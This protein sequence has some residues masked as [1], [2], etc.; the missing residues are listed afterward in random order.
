MNKVKRNKPEPKSKGGFA[1]G[2]NQVLSGRFLLRDYVQSNL[3]FLIYIVFLMLSYIAYGYFAENNMKELVSA[4]AKLNELKT[5]NLTLQAHLSKLRAQSSVEQS[6][7]DL[8]LVES[9][10]PPILIAVPESELIQPEPVK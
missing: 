1:R 5:R 6:I 8:G 9:T 7:K 2:V 10:T 4:N 3:T